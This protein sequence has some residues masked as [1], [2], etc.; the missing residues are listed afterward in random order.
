L[1]KRALILLQRDWGLKI[2]RHIVNKLIEDGYTISALTLKRSTHNYFLT[3][4]EIKFCHLINLDTII[5]N[6]SAVSG[7]DKITIEDVCKGLS[8]KSVWPFFQERLYIR[9]YNDKYYYSFRQNRNDDDCRALIKAYYISISELFDHCKP[10]VI[11]SPNFAATIHAM[12]YHFGKNNDVPMFAL[13]PSFVSG[14]YSCN[15]DYSWGSSP[16]TS[17]FNQLIEGDSKS[18]NW[19]KSK[20]YVNR[21]RQ[22]FIEPTG[23]IENITNISGIIDEKF[24]RSI[25]LPNIGFVKRSKI[26]LR[27]F[28]QLLNGSYRGTQNKLRNIGN[29]PDSMSFRT[30]VRDYF[31]HKRNMRHMFKIKYLEVLPKHFAYLPLQV[32]P[33][34]AIDMIA[35]W[36][37]NQIEVARLVAQSLPGDMTLVVKE[38]PAMIGK[39]SLSYY[40]KLLNSVN[41]SLV[42]PLLHNSMLLN[43]ASIIVAMTG[44]S[45]FE[46]S[47]Y[48][49]PVIQLGDLSINQLLP[50]VFFHNHFSTLGEKISAVMENF[51]FDEDSEKRLTAF[52]AAIYDTGY[53]ID[54]GGAVYH[55][56]DLDVIW[57]AYK[58]EISR[59]R[60]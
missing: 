18:D 43:K 28:R 19:E 10:E 17:R 46:S 20:N 47:I 1:A 11:I 27:P 21:F 44:T 58:Y 23:H 51:V 53:P 38:H 15:T 32:Q 48:K 9:N 36:F 42:S 40:E 33:E 45:I 54:Y 41:V 59:I 37:N 55:G 3:Q 5:E 16:L 13:E 2:G 57:E 8:V 22:Q 26:R 6:P 50:N 60:N 24:R 52:V 7:V 29:T 35:P 49:K 34:Q 25:N 56:R 39:R 12:L 4:N 31:T 14:I 30:F